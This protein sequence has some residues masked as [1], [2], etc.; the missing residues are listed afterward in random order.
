[1]LSSYIY[2]INFLIGK[3]NVSKRKKRSLKKPDP[4]KAKTKSKLQITVD[5]V[6]H[7]VDRKNVQLVR[8]PVIQKY[9]EFDRTKEFKCKNGLKYLKTLENDIVKNGLKEPL[10]L[11]VSKESQRAYL[12]EGNHRIICLESLGVHW[13]P[14]KVGYWFLNDPK[15]AEYPFIPAILKDFPE[16]ITPSICGFETKDL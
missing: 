3:S 2:D 4:K 15:S 9:I 8:L 12:S 7:L 13:I 11:A 6:S 5:V 1:M 10:I 16:D 14:L